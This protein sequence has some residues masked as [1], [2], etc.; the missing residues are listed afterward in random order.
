MRTRSC[1]ESVSPALGAYANMYT[2]YSKKSASESDERDVCFGKKEKHDVNA[3]TYLRLPALQP[4]TRDVAA[5]DIPPRSHNTTRGWVPHTSRTTFKSPFKSK[6]STN[7]GPRLYT[8][9]IALPAAPAR[10][11]P[12][13]FTKFSFWSCHAWVPSR[14][15]AYEQCIYQSLSC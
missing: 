5:V 15:R 12:W 9:Y 8:L 7:D 10:P 6:S 3:C 14:F 13:R 4:R 2:L 11:T 1:A